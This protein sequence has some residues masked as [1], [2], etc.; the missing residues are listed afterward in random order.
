MGLFR[1]NKN[2]KGRAG[3]I[4]RAK[5]KN[6]RAKQK[7][8]AKVQK[9]RAIRRKKVQTGQINWK[10]I[11]VVFLILCFLVFTNW[12]I[13]FSEA[14]KIK[15]IDVIG[16]DD[17]E[18]QIIS[19][20]NEVG[21]KKIFNQEVGQNLILFSSNKLE[22][23]IRDKFFIVKDVEIKKVFP[24]KIIIK[25]TKRKRIFLWKQKNKCR[26]LDE[27]GNSFEK[28][29]CQKDEDELLKICK[30]KTKKLNLDCQVFLATDGWDDNMD[31]SLI[32]LIIKATQQ[33]LRE[34]KT[35]FYFEDDLVIVVS[36]PTA[37]EIRVKSNNH[38]ELWFSLD[39]NLKKQLE[40]FRILL[41][42][43]ID[44]NDLE[45]MLYID[46]RLSDKIIYRMK[47]GADSYESTNPLQ[48]Y[49]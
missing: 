24:S 31:V 10:K 17:V 30:N 46:L 29:D 45:N 20:E 8:Q 36:N 6:V 42:Q 25:V 4:R 12:V 40:E 1:K 14:M 33:I 41:E 21:R 32:N 13:F 19:L 44:L 9:R 26:F 7:K 49:E 28:F 15:E 48:I 23:L 22:K 34:L 35:T 5:I 38:G 3:K 47:E 43:K 16:Y 2:K 27:D 11:G 39:K 18:E 37:K